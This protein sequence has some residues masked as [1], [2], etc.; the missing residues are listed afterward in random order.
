LASE[1]WRSRKVVVETKVV[2]QETGAK[3]GGQEVRRGYFS[4]LSEDTQKRLRESRAR[5]MIAENER[6]AKEAEEK[7]KHLESPL[8]LLATAMRAMRVAEQCAKKTG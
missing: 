6:K 1:S 5:M 2:E 8:A 4:E 3:V 7:L